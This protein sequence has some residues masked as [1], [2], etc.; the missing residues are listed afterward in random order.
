M[1]IALTHEISPEINKCE[2]SYINR[3]PIDFNLAVKQHE[4][5]CDTLREEG[6]KVTEMSINS[7]YPDSTFVE[8]TAVVVDEVAV[9]ANMGAETRRGEASGV[10]SELKKYRDIFHIK[11]PA[12]LDGGDVLKVGRD[13]YVGITPRTNNLGA[14]SLA[15]ALK[16][17][18]Y[19]VRPVSVKDCLHFKSAC[20]AIDNQTL[21]VNPEWIDIKDF[22]G[23]RTINIDESEPW[24]ANSLCIN[25][26]VYIHAQYIKTAEILQK[27]GFS[28]KTIDISELIKAEAGLTCS[29]II[30]N[31][32]V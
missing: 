18:G 26:T 15:S 24:A 19:N 9:M 30:F 23:F 27:L 2:L 8:D 7:E 3:N 14:E 22:A 17:L 25:N 12:T 21:L 6:L 29:S 10:E 20:T 5:Y 4:K 1:L 32:P 31:H 28:V 16:P 11:H 13:I